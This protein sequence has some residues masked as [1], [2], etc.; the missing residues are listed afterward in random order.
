MSE[1]PQDV[2]AG[3]ESVKVVPAVTGRGGPKRV[4]LVVAGLLVAL[5]LLAEI[6]VVHLETH[7]TNWNTEFQ[8]ETS[9]QTLNGRAVLLRGFQFVPVVNVT[10]PSG[11][12]KGIATA[13]AEAIRKASSGGAS[14]EKAKLEITITRLT[15]AGT[16]WVPFI[17]TGSCNFAATYVLE[18]VAGGSSISVRGQ[19]TGNVE[20]SM[21]GLCST[22][23][24]RDHMSKAVANAIISDIQKMIAKNG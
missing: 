12:G 5:V 15:P 2:L 20:Q 3:N 14:T 22:A 24:F 23:R 13:A 19:I 16:P 4:L 1:S 6:G 7:Q 8:Y 21:K 10:V 18:A 11:S 17:K 9:R